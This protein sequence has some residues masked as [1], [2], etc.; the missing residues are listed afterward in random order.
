MG[1]AESDS[2]GRVMSLRNIAVSFHRRRKV[3]WPIQDVSFDLYRGETLGIVGRNGV[4]KTTLLKVM[5]GILRPDRGELRSYAHTVSLLSLHL[6]FLPL[7]SGRE[8]AVMGG[9]LLGMGAGKIRAL[10]DSIVDFAELGDFIDEPMH[11]YSAGMK[12]RL[13]FS[14]AFH[15]EPDVLLIDEVLGVGDA[16][17]REKS[18]K[19]M[20]QKLRSEKTIVLVSHNEATIRELCDRAVWIENGKT[21]VEGEVTSVMQQYNAAVV[22]AMRQAA[23]RAK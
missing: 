16:E 23:G 6:G 11:T 10:M 5:A 13:G 9:I 4:G 8:N 14:V 7:L 12:A 1:A 18:S 20:K 22:P 21:R 17:F 2:Q 19:A 3:F 15:A